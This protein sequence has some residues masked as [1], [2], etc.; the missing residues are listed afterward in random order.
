MIVSGSYSAYWGLLEIDEGSWVPYD[1]DSVNYL[2]HTRTGFRHNHSFNGKELKF[3]FHGENI[4]DTIQVG[5]NV[6]VDF[7]L[8]EYGK[9][10]TEFLHWASL[11]GEGTSPLV[12]RSGIIHRPGIH[13]WERAKPLVLVSCNGTATQP[14]TRIYPKTILMHDSTIPVDFAHTERHVALK[15]VVLPVKYFTM[16]EDDLVNIYTNSPDKPDGTNKL[17][18]WF[19]LTAP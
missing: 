11:S 2:G 1:T 18:Y 7:V 17:L 13:L 19:D 3:E 15:L 16:D 9:L 6:S 4:F 12:F 5:A 8:Q 10:A 14:Y